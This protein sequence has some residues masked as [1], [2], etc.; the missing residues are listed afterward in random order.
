MEGDCRVEHKMNRRRH[1]EKCVFGSIS[2]LLALFSFADYSEGAIFKLKIKPAAA[3][4]RSE[5]SMDSKILFQS[6]AGTVLESDS[7]SGEW[8][9]IPILQPQ[10]ANLKYG[11]VHQSVVDVFEESKVAK[12]EEKKPEQKATEVEKP[13]IKEEKKGLEEGAWILRDRKV[14]GRSSEESAKEGIKEGDASWILQKGKPQSRG[15]E[16]KKNSWTLELLEKGAKFGFN[17]SSLSLNVLTPGY[18]LNFKT[19]F[20][21]GGYLAFKLGGW[22]EIEPEFFFTMKGGKEASTWDLN[23]HS[24]INTYKYSY[25]YNFYYLE[26]PLLLKA[27]IPVTSALNAYVLAGPY[28]SLKLAANAVLKTTDQNDRS[29]EQAFSS[30]PNFIDFGAVLGGGA[31]LKLGGKKRISIEIRYEPGFVN[32]GEGMKTRNLSFLLGFA[33]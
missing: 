24:Y 33:L 22:L 10:A 20:C 4:I 14:E 7:K 5:P 6:F 31:S 21:L 8:Y 1:R 12:E 19:G 16:G 11:Y 26:I 23:I 2:L 17:L 3:N 13:V 32:V 30:D 18:E 27:S 9:R 29:S 28:V 25:T 15:P